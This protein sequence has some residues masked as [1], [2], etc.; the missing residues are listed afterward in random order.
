[1]EVEWLQDEP[2]LKYEPIEMVRF[3][4]LFG[5]SDSINILDGSRLE[6][7]RIWDARHVRVFVLQRR[8]RS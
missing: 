6:K 8:G 4:S 7:G 1:M 2:M 3:I 5:E